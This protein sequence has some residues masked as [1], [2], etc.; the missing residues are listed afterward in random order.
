VVLGGTLAVL[1]GNWLADSL[2][3]GR[4]HRAHR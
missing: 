4:W 1:L 2:G 3:L